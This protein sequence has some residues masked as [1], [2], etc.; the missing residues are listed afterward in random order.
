MRDIARIAAAVEKDPFEFGNRETHAS[1]ESLPLCS[2][3]GYFPGPRMMVKVK[4]KVKVKVTAPFK[5]RK[6][7]ESARIYEWI[8][9]E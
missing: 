2:F 7:R 9:C 8:A 1:K 6:Q 4:V 3:V 5:F